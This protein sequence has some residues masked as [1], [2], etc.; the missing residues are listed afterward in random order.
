MAPAGYVLSRH[1][2]RRALHGRAYLRWMDRVP[3]EYREF[4]L[5]APP[6][7][8]PDAVNDPDCLAILRHHRSL[9][10]LALEAHNPIFFLKPADGAVGAHAVA[11]RDAYQ[12]FRNLALRIAEK[13]SL[14]VL[15]TTQGSHDS[16]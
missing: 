13:C 1:V 11:V 10:T 2:T 4:V 8:P 14:P 15:Q 5:D 7:Q 9:F 3:G 6:I 16:W 12:D